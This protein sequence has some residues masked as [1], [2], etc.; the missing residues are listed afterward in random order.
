MTPSGNIIGGPGVRV[1][2]TPHGYTI[3]AERRAGGGG[4]SAHPLK[5]I[6]ATKEGAAAAVT[7]VDGTVS[8]VIPQI[9]GVAITATPK[10]ALEVTGNGFVVLI[11]TWANDYIPRSAPVTADFVFIEGDPNGDYAF[12]ETLTES[13]MAHARVWTTGSGSTL[14]ISKILTTPGGNIT[15]LRNSYNPTEVEFVA[16]RA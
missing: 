4:S 1:I 7:V 15:V 16:L 13:R 12:T 2:R 5:V 8:R 11:T 9:D 3:E 14:S 10:P 6:G